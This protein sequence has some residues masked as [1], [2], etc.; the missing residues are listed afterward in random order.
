MGGSEN[1]FLMDGFVNINPF[2]NNGIQK[3][4]IKYPIEINNGNWGC[5]IVF[6]KNNGE[7]LYHNSNA[8][9]LNISLLNNKLELVYFSKDYKMLL[10]YEIIHK[11]KYFLKVIDCFEEKI[12]KFDVLLSKIDMNDFIVFF[13]NNNYLENT[14][15]IHKFNFKES[16]LIKDKIKKN[17]FNRWF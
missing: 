16:I 3:Y 9:A 7:V 13:S 5:E 15:L 10:F 11:E 1:I 12:Y 4:K 2:D 17:I 8:L 6:F 14:N